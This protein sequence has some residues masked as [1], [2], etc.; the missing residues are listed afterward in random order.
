LA[1]N[2]NVMLRLATLAVVI[3]LGAGASSVA[4]PF[5]PAFVDVFRGGL[6]ELGLLWNLFL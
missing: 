4:T 1:D 5:T 3:V 6:A 2:E